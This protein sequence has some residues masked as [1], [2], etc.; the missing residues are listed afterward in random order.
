MQ[1]KICF[2][3]G[4]H[5]APETILPLIYEAVERHITEYGVSEFI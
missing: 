1:H 3:I 5:D 2:F 4:H